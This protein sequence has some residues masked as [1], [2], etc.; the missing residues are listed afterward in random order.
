MEND[1]LEK[2]KVLNDINASSQH[3][4]NVVH[5]HEMINCND[6]KNLKGSF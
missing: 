5:G 3:T 4:E 6:L 2:E 1:K